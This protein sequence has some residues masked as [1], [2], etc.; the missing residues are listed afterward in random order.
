MGPKRVPRWILNS[1]FQ[2]P[3]WNNNSINSGH[4]L[5]TGSKCH[6]EPSG[7]PFGSRNG[8]KLAPFGDRKG[9]ETNAKV[10]TQRFVPE[11]L[12]QDT[13]GIC[14]HAQPDAKKRALHVLALPG[15]SWRLLEA[16]GGFQMC[17][18]FQ[19]RFLNAFLPKMVRKSSHLGAHIASK[20]GF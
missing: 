12:V 5:E 2:R 3:K 18:L 4:S 8:A 16:L 15:L 19:T 1:Y 10:E 20:N 17:I 14:S 7:E 9:W 13:C 6:W 11:Q